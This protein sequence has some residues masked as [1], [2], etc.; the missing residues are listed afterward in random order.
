MVELLNTHHFNFTVADMD[1]SLAFWRDALGLELLND[2]VS[3][4]GYL[5]EITGYP[6]ARLR[7]AFLALPGT[8]ARLELIQYLQPAGPPRAQQPR[9][10]AGAAHLC[11]DVPDVQ[12]AYAELRARGV[13][14]TSPPVEI[15]SAANR[16]AWGV[17]LTDPDGI[18]LEL[19]Q[20][21]AA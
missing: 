4:A 11:F 8:A 6:G 3:D 12:A 17:Y 13:A 19:R 5:S 21:P 16:G 14:F 1:R 15:T 2:W 18:T 10:V 9:N 20:P 7:L